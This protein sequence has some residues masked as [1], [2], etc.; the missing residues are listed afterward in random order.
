MSYTE[1]K[2]KY[3]ALG[4]E[5]CACPHEL[6]PGIGKD[7][8]AEIQ[9]ENMPQVAAIPSQKEYPYAFKNCRKPAAP[10]V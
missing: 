1:A 10:G 9:K 5:K 3:A 2:E 6:H 4:R 8:G 7:P